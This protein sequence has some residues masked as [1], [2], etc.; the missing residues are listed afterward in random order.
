MSRHEWPIT[1]TVHGPVAT[2][3]IKARAIVAAGW[4]QGTE[5]DGD[6]N[7]CL[8][9]ALRLA[10]LEGR[11]DTDAFNYLTGALPRQYGFKPLHEF[12]DAPSTT[13]ADI[14]AFFDR[15]IWMADRDQA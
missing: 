9:E 8:S 12:N 6:G 14:L 3:L 5:F 1:E 10:G 15:A 11:T 4:C 13:K 7:Y 2:I